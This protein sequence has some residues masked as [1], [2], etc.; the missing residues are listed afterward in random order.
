MIP[1]LENAE[2]VRL[3]VM[4][5]NTYLCSPELLDPTMRLRDDVA[6]RV[7][8][9][10][11]LFFAGQMTGVEGYTESAA[12]GIIAGIN[13][14]RAV[15]G[16]APFVPPRPTMI[17][18]LCDYI[19]HGPADNF[20]PMNSNLGLLPPLEILI[21][22]KEERQAALIQRGLETMERAAS[23]VGA[24]QRPMFGCSG[25]QADGGRLDLA[26]TPE[27]LNT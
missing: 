6:A 9:R 11:P 13:A 15:H 16:E 17:G 27:H 2:F 20:Q 25:V 5:R 12:T 8:R 14:A 26:R 10:A 24:A 7:G 23:G 1:G 3:G 4:H 19:A 21:R 22:K 18:S